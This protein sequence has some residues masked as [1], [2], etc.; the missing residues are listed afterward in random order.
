MLAVTTFHNY[1]SAVTW[2][3]IQHHG[4]CRPLLLTAG[5]C[6]HLDEAGQ[7]ELLAAGRHGVHVAVAENTTEQGAPPREAALVQQARDHH[8]AQHLRQVGEGQAVRA[9]VLVWNRDNGRNMAIWTA[10]NHRVREHKL[11]TLPVSFCV[12]EQRMGKIVQSSKRLMIKRLHFN[13]QVVSVV[14]LRNQT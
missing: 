14:R 10:E 3:S 2:L 6:P 12:I 5:Y 11:T 1:N 7:H 4:P 9:R 8:S 13:L